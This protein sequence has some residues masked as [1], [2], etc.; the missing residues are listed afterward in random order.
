MAKPIYKIKDL[1]WFTKSMCMC[2]V[3]EVHEN[4]YKNQHAYTIEKLSTKKTLFCTEAGLAPVTLIS[5]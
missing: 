1:V 5:S 3:V 4:G 2:R